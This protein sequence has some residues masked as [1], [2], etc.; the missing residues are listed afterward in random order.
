MASENIFYGHEIILKLELCQY[1]RKLNEYVK[2]NGKLFTI[3][4]ENVEVFK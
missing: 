4:V 2:I 1:L 3:K